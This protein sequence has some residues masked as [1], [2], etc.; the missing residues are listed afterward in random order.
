MPTEIAKPPRA[1]P[2]KQFSVFTPNRLGR[3]HDMTRLLSSHSVHVLAMTVM[4]TTDSAIIRFVVDDPDQARKLLF[5][6]SFPFTESNVLVAEVGSA[7]NLHSL[8]AALL[9]AEVN[10]NYLY[11]FIPHPHGKS[12]LALSMED[13]DMA[14]QVLKRHQFRVLHQADISR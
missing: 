13:N 1:D 5:K 11:S 14:E 6:H 12:L 9:E 8:L 2:V 7:T 10:I 3:L 4:D